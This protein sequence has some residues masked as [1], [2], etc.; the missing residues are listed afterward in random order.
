MINGD[1]NTSELDEDWITALKYVDH[2]IITPGPVSS[3]I[4]R[5]LSTSFTEQQISELSI[6][7]ALFHGFSKMLIG[8][9]R[10]PE[11]MEITVVPTPHLPDTALVSNRKSHH[12]FSHLFTYI[13]EIGSRWIILERSL[14]SM[15][16]LPKRVLDLVKRR[17]SEVLGVTHL[18]T[19]IDDTCSEHD[20]FIRGIAEN[21]VFDIRSITSSTRE[22]ITGIYG[23][24]AVLQLMFAMA[25]YDGIFRMEASK[26]NYS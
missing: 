23:S 16:A 21:F 13:H 7:V 20:E 6:G 19:S 4:S 2:F 3:E 25:L 12:D 11:E 10:E 15:D 24:D 9:G 8:L 17:I 5:S 22:R 14:L 26:I 18:T 1:W